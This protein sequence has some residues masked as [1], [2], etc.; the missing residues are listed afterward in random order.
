[1]RFYFISLRDTR[2]LPL[3]LPPENTGFSFANCQPQ[4]ALINVD[5]KVGGSVEEQERSGR[6]RTGAK[7]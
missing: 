7:R 1:M 4:A 6:R 5:G 2:S 3:S